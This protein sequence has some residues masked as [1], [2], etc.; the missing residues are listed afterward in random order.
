MSFFM[1]VGHLVGIVAF[2][3]ILA[4]YQNMSLLTRLGARFAHGAD[5][6]QVP[7]N[8]L[9]E[10]KADDIQG[11]SV[12]FEQFRGRVSLFVNVATN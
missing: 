10:L 6:L 11:T 3:S 2:F 12:D 5:N 8:S 4:A 7:V 9:F 1:R